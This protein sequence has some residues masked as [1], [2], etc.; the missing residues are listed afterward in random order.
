MAGGLG[1]TS[2]CIFNEVQYSNICLFFV[3]SGSALIKCGQTEQRLG[4]AERDYISASANG[5]IQPLKAFLDGDMK[6]VQVLN[7]SLIKVLF[8]CK[9]HIPEKT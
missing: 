6:T 5:F 4:T 7:S 1:S 2:S 3:F 8:Q 9:K